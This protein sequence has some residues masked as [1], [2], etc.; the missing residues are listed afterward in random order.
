MPKIHPT[1]IV[2]KA[3]RL[4]DSDEI[5]AYS[6]VGPGVTL[7]EGVRLVSHVCIEGVTEIGE[8]C[9]IHPFASLGGAPQHLG[10]KGEPTQLI[11]GAR[12]VIREHVTMNTGTV[13]GG[14]V[15]RVGSDSLYMT[16]SHVAHDCVV[17]DNVVFANN[18]TLGG[19]VQVGE[20][21]FLGGLAAVHQFS[22]IGHYAFIGGVS[23]VTKD[24]IPFG[25]V[26]GVHAHLEGLN[27]VGLKRRG[28]SREEINDLR[29]AYRLLFAEEGTFQE[30][31]EDVGRVFSGAKRVMEIVDFIRADANRPLCLPRNDD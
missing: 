23:A 13:A 5:G 24:V 11:I 8:G 18:A 4:A 7:G 21:V 2:D 26:W 1:A 27:L 16:A 17:G 20:F 6:T 15:T 12:N 3:A 31:L 29:S 30:R 22:R 25:S 14:G 10:Y 28:F 9:V 19:H